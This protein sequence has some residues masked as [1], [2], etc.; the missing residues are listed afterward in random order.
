MDKITTINDKIE[1]LKKQK[2]RIQAQQAVLFQ[3][4]AEKIFGN[5]FSPEVALV[6]LSEWTTATDSKKKEWTNRA[7]SFR[8][9]SVQNSQG[10]TAIPEPTSHQNGKTQTAENG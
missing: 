9:S 3:H 5:S 4:E 6:M 8:F 2:I 1:K 7:N 10:K